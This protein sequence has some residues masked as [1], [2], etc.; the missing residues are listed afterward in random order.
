MSIILKKKKGLLTPK[1]HPPSPSQILGSLGI[2]S[3]L[4][5]S[6]NKELAIDT[7]IEEHIEK[8]I[9]EKMLFH[10]TRLLRGLDYFP[11]YCLV[12]GEKSVKTLFIKKRAW[13]NFVTIDRKEMIVSG[14]SPE[15]FIKFLKKKRCR[16]VKIDRTQLE[17]NI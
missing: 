3:V 13:M 12:D 2:G 5:A 10:S 14:A 17:K 11:T 7:I 6:I 15:E 16:K 9:M 8:L 4:G 1:S